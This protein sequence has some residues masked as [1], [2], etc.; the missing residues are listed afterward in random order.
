M[1]HPIHYSLLLN[2]ATLAVTG[3]LS[4]FLKNPL[5]VVIGLLV[6]QHMAARFEP[7]E[8]DLYERGE[9]DGG[10]QPMGFTAPIS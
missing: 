1:L 8:R 2:C 9:Y 6:M 7:S 4:W 3:T 10:E 5:I